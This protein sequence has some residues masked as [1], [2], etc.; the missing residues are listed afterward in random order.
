MVTSTTGY[1]WDFCGGHLA[2]DFVN[3][4]SDRGGERVERLNVYG[5]LL[6]WATAR[7]AVA[8]ADARRLAKAADA[9]PGA[10]DEALCSAVALREALYRI[11]AA[12]SAQRHAR[13]EDL[14]LLDAHLRAAYARV[15][16]APAS[17]RLALAFDAPDD[18]SLLAP[19]VMPVVRAAVDL[20]TSNAIAR[21]H[22]CAERSC[23]WLFLDTTRSGTRRWCDMKVCGNR[24]KA[25]RHRARMTQQPQRTQRR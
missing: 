4:V 18:R 16:L 15:R 14:A 12:V 19:I 24:A 6:E 17:E 10:A 9:R 21:V 8:A 1:V 23:A 2:L 25:R 20:L 22:T 13:R 7:G 3:T 5:D 11:V